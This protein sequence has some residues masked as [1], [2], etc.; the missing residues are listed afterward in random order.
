MFDDF[1]GGK[2][3]D[4]FWLKEGG[5]KEAWKTDK[6]QGDNRL[7]VHRIAGDGNGAD[8]FGFGTI[9]F[10]DFGIQLDFYLLEDPFPTK[11]EILL[12]ASTTSSFISL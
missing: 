4:N 6:F 1:K 8:D 3:N 2:I 9:K 11:I 10:K 7:E 5:V 12:R